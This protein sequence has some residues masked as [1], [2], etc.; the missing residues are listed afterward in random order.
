M[1]GTAPDRCL[2]YIAHHEYNARFFNARWMSISRQS[3]S[4]SPGHCCRLAARVSWLRLLPM[5]A[6]AASNAGSSAGGGLRRGVICRPVPD[7]TCNR[8]QSPRDSPATLAC[9]C[10]LS[11]VHASTRRVTILS[12]GAWDVVRSAIRLC[13]FIISPRCNLGGS[14]GGLAPLASSL[15]SCAA[16]NTG[17]C[18]PLRV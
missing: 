12:S 1:S 5:R 8:S 13:Q 7:D 3:S 14:R 2:Y 11:R 15:Y 4:S 9:A 17:V 10:H 18:L 16:C 6:I